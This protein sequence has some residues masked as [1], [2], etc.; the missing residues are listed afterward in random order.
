MI[1]SSYH[2]DSVEESFHLAL[3]LELSF[4]EKFISKY[5]KQC[6]KCD[7]YRLYDYQCLSIQHT[8]IIQSDDVDDSRIIEDVYV[9]SEIATVDEDLLV[10]SS[11]PI[12]DEVHA[13][14]EG[15]S[16]VIGAVVESN[17][18]IPDDICVHVEDTRMYYI[19]LLHIMKS[20]NRQQ[21]AMMVTNLLHIHIIFC[22]IYN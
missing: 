20:L 19:C 4:K 5:R 8:N 22:R 14:S 16:D 10:D 1:T 11:A 3:E 13:S 12:L 9:L 17:A 7:G 21:F 6:S 2:V 18:L 15:T